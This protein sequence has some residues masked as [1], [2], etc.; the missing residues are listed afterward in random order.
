MRG[1]VA[2][3]SRPC[4]SEARRFLAVF[5]LVCTLA[6]L[7][8]V[9]GLALLQRGGM[10]PAA[11][12]TATWCFNMKFAFL[13]EATLSDR[14]LVAVGSS[15]T[16][17]NLDM[18]VFERQ[19]AGTRALNAAPCFLQIDQTAF[20]TAFLLD[21]MPRVDSVLVTLAPRDFEACR[22]EHTAF[23][24]PV[25]AGAYVDRTMPTWLVHFLGF[26]P[27]WLLREV[28]RLRRTSELQGEG[29]FEDAYGSSILRRPGRY[30]PALKLDPRCDNV[31][32][33]LEALVAARGA[34]LVVAT[35]PVM[36]AWAAEFDPD[37]ASVEAWSRRLASSLGKP[38][39]LFIDGRALAWGDERF[40]DPVHLLYPH[41]VAFS[42]FVAA[43]IEA[44]RRAGAGRS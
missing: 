40:A 12:V 37:G 41:H 42:E 33:R 22:R 26:R 35:V 29:P 39:S 9:G 8:M 30:W 24:Q 15:A 44:H 7:A 17:R 13:R 23:F 27:V 36:P 16:W 34:R 3:I 5:F 4:T 43:A 14:S 38:E 21:R 18:S 25:L 20:L 2:P 19:T 32:P 31:L 28:L 11:P 1:A 10:L 6:M